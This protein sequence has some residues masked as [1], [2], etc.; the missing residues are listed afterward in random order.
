MVWMLEENEDNRKMIESICDGSDVELEQALQNYRT[1]GREVLGWDQGQADLMEC[2]LRWAVEARRKGR[3]QQEEEQRRQGEQGQHPGQEDSKQD[4]QVDLG[5]EEQAQA[6]CTD[7]PEVMG[8][9]AE[10][11]TGRGSS[12]LVRGGDE[13]CRTDESS[14]KG[15]GKGNGGK[16]EHEGKG[17]KGG[18]SFQQST[19]M[20]KGEEEQETAEEDEGRV[21][22]APNMGAGGS[23]PQAMTDPEEE[24]M[25]EEEKKGVRR[26]RWADSE[27]GERKEEE[28]VLELVGLETERGDR[29]KEVE[30]KR[31]QEAERKQKQAREEE[32][33]AQEAREEESRA[34]EA[35]VKETRAQEEQARE[36]RKAQ[37]ER[38]ERINAQEEQVEAQEGHEEAKEVTTTQEKCVEAKKENS[39]HEENDVSN[40]HMTW[41]RNAWWVRMDNGP[42]L[43]TARDRRK[44]W[45]AAT[46]AA[47]ETRETGRVAGGEREEWETRRKES[48]ANV[49]HVVFHFPTATTTAAAPATTTTAAAGTAA[50]VAATRHSS[51]NRCLQAERACHQGRIALPV[52]NERGSDLVQPYRLPPSLTKGL[53]RCRIRCSWTPLLLSMGLKIAG[54][55]TTTPIERNTTFLMKKGQTFMAY[56]DNQPDVLIRIYK[57]E[58]A[59]TEDNN[60]DL[61]SVTWPTSG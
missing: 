45:R 18:K 11:R 41:W 60:W 55:V 50:A 31:E 56:V 34:Q 23:H 13:R 49:L 20:M 26:L 14:R 5:D 2:G 32:R 33:R 6:K 15:K 37:E 46:K 27:D 12:G 43:R 30:E 39:V 58:R 24:E 40:R 16:G 3:R 44:V 54:D 8:R 38:E 57:V 19:K 7:E 48:N 17:D 53:H 42:H 1:A 52:V 9:L 51:D 10:V 36:E 22:M 59:M 47:R 35:R 28:V 25:K 61:P 21:R 29:E 4:K